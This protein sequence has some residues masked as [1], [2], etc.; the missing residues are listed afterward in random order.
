MNVRKKHN[1]GMSAVG[2]LFL[3]I[4]AGGIA[5]AWFKFIGPY[6]FE[7]KLGLADLVLDNSGSLEETQTRVDDLWN[8]IK[9]I[10]K[11]IREI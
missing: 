3:C 6:F 9:G 11:E 7:Q 8:Q 1:S 10:Q 5:L 2:L 4:L